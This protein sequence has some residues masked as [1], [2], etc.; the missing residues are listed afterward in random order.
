MSLGISIMI[1]K[2]KK[3]IPGVFSFMNPLSAEVGPNLLRYKWLAFSISLLLLSLFSLLSLCRL[4]S[5]ILKWIYLH[6][7]I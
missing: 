6:G 3:D 5:N 2:P 4:C 1:Q 7:V